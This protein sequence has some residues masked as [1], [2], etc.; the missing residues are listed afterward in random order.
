MILQALYRSQGRCIDE[1]G[2]SKMASVRSFLHERAGSGKNEKLSMH[3][4]AGSGK[5]QKNVSA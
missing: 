1:G 4:R 5:K 2:A 3:E